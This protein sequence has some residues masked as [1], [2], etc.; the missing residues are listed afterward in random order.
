MTS[1][2]LENL[3]G[4]GKPLAKEPPD[5]REVAG[6][7]RSAL[8]R[9]KDA[10]NPARPGLQRGPCALPGCTALAWPLLDPFLN[11]SFHRLR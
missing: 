2:Q 6:L 10:G 7:K 4:P 1:S 5:A 9:L 11:A 3:C 8:A